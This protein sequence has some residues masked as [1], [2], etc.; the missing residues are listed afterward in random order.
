VRAH[1]EIERAGRP[2]DRAVKGAEVPVG[3]TEWTELHET[4]KCDKPFA[5]GWQAYIGCSQDGGRFRADA[6]RLYQ[7]EYVPW[8]AGAAGPEN[9]FTNA[10][11]EEGQKPFFFMFGEQYNLRKTFRRASFTLTRLLANMGVAGETPLLSRFATPLGEGDGEGKPGPSVVQNGDFSQDADG[12]G[13]PDDWQFQ[14]GTPESACA[15]EPLDGGWSLRMDLKGYGGKD[16]ADV[17]LAQHEVPMVEGQWYRISFRAK[18]EGLRGGRIAFTVTN[19][20]VWRSFFEYQYFA[21]GEEWREFRYVLQSNASAA[22]KT[23]LQIWHGNLGTVWLADLKMEPVP[24]P[25][26]G[27]WASG[28]YLDDPEEWDDPYRFFRW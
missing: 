19:T 23:R 27:R 3:D 1:L 28:F 8:Q 5:E 14:P 21:P 10:G 25:A 2:W 6:F 9:L 17:M 4:F 12:D 22:A 7:G 13:M 20:E 18:A 11:F 26:T 15:R 16:R 24:P